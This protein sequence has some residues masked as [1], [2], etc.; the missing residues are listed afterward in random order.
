MNLELLLI[1][2]SPFLSDMV[3]AQAADV[4]RICINIWGRGQGTVAIHELI[5]AILQDEPLKMR[6]LAEIFH[7]DI[8]SIHELWMIS[9]TESQVEPCLQL[10]RQIVRRLWWGHFMRGSDL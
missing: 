7:G 1:K 3:L 10:A 4:T 2:G 8:A 5:R 9:G 6:R